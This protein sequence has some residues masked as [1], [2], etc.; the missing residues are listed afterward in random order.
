MIIIKERNHFDKYYLLEKVDDRFWLP[1][2]FVIF[3]ENKKFENRNMFQ[4]ERKV[5]LQL[6]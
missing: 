6:K 1:N 4:K 5:D 2:K 3:E